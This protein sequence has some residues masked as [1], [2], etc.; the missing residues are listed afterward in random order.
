MANAVDYAVRK[1]PVQTRIH[2]LEE[3]KRDPRFWGYFTKLAT[4][5]DPARAI[6]DD[7]KKAVINELD[8]SSH[9][10]TA[11]KW[12]VLRNKM[13][14]SMQTIGH[15]YRAHG[16]LSSLAAFVMGLGQEDSGLVTSLNMEETGT[17]VPIPGLV[18]SLDEPTPSSG[19]PGLVT[20]LSPSSSGQQAPIEDPSA[21]EESAAF[22]ESLDKPSSASSAAAAAAGAAPAAARAATTKAPA[23]A[24]PAGPSIWS[25]IASALTTAGGAGA[26]IYSQEVQ[27]QAATKAQQTL[28]S[29]QQQA[30]LR[31]QQAAALSAASKTTTS[32]VLYGLLGLLGVGGL[33]M[34]FKATSGGKGRGR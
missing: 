30:A 8:P 7:M 12:P 4:S 14:S 28:I 23:P 18:T 15:H 10:D 1:L 29:A 11:G 22:K 5:S 27:K 6:D 17:S 25:T 19:V 21:G 9:R 2:A 3:G 26:A 32:Y 33:L 34:L 13:R 24:A 20:S 31:A 16:N